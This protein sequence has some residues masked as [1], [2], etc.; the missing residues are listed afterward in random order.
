M[1]I[2]IPDNQKG[3]NDPNRCKGQLF[4]LVQSFSD[5]CFLA[6]HREVLDLLEVYE[7]IFLLPETLH[8]VFQ[9]NQLQYKRLA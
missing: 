6:T 9:H 4:D 8:F 5:E 7:K 2:I 1:K 3:E